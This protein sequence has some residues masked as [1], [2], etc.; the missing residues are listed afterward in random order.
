MTGQTDTWVVKELCTVD[1][2][3]EVEQVIAQ[4]FVD[5]SDNLANAEN[6]FLKRSGGTMTGTITSQTIIPSATNK[7]NLGSSSY[8]YNNIYS[9]YAYSTYGFFESSD[10]TK[11]DFYEDIDVDL[12]K[13]LQLPKKY[14][15][16][17]A[18]DKKQR[19]IGT[20]AQAVKE[21][22]PELVDGEEGNLTVDYAKLS[23]IALKGIDILNDKVKQLEDRL[24]KLEEIILKK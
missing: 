23:V 9:S 6:T 13:I 1:K 8:R 24:S 14:F 15:A 4:T 7:Y 20:S 10:E 11:K 18:D 12:D 16:W 22:Y 19:Q 21:L 3:E 17:K 5:L 2:L